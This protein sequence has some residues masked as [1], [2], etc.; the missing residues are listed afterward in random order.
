[1]YEC[2]IILALRT[3]TFIKSIK[4]RQFITEKTIIYIYMYMLDE[5]IIGSLV[6]YPIMSNE[7]YVLV[8]LQ[9]FV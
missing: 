2:T 7:L 5:C 8:T 4:S 3:S 1:M 6:T 9:L